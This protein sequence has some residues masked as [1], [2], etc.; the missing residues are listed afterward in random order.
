MKY[1]YKKIKLDFDKFA[2]ILKVTL[3]YYKRWYM[4]KIFFFSVNFMHQN[5]INE[6]CIN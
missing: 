1:L 3:L 4:K 6:S 2:F 5:V